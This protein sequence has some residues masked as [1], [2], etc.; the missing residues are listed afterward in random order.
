[1]IAEMIQNIS[2]LTIHFPK[3]L[4]NLHHDNY[5]PYLSLRAAQRSHR[6]IHARAFPIYHQDAA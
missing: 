2:I 1:M 6:L 4:V 3:V 5:K